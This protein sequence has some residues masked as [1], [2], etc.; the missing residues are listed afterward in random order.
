MADRKFTY[1][2]QGIKQPPGKQIVSSKVDY[3]VRGGNHHA[4][5]KQSFGM[6][7]TAGDAPVGLSGD[8]TNSRFDNFF[9]PT[10]SPDLYSLPYT[11]KD[12]RDLFL[13]FYQRDPYVG[14]AI[15]LLTELPIS[16]VHHT[17]PTTAD[18]EKAHEVLR[19]TKVLSDKINMFELLM[20]IAH[21]YWLYGNVY[22]YVEKNLKGDDIERILILD[23]NVV[24]VEKSYFSSNNSIFL[25]P[26]EQLRHL[27]KSSFI[28]N[29]IR[30]LLNSIPD[31]I[32]R[33]IYDNKKIELNTDPFA[34]TFVHHI[35]RRKSQYDILGEPIL[36]RCLNDLMYRERLRQAQVAIAMRN[37]S[38][39]HLITTTAPL[40]DAQLDNLRDQVDASME[41]PDYVILTTFDVNWN[42]VGAENRLLQ[43]TSEWEE[44]NTRIAAGLGLRKEMIFGDGVFGDTKLGLDVLDKRFSL[45]RNKLQEFVEKKLWAPIC[46]K[47][48]YIERT[49][50]ADLILTP[51][52]AFT[53]L[54]LRDNEAVFNNLFQLYQ[55]GS[56]SVRT[57]LEL[58]N[59]DPD[60]EYEYLQSDLFTLNDARFNDLLA[61]FYQTVGGDLAGD[62]RFKKLIAER[63]L[64]IKNYEDLPTDL[65]ASYKNK[66]VKDTLNRSES[67]SQRVFDKTYIAGQSDKLELNNIQN[68]LI[69]SLAKKVK[70]RYS[71]SKETIPVKK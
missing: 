3:K 28:D 36:R 33:A 25:V 62:P 15:D 38:P 19:Y 35:H 34:G 13:W 43:L 68:M 50:E 9:H 70:N 8:A 58:F 7:F 5:S 42:Q 24:E 4:F 32:Q 2:A 1:S 16:R 44:V 48:G 20:D 51:G 56:L 40:D 67:D 39:K 69:G 52:L 27:I 47:K 46:Y 21:E 12:E 30:K 55:K 31:E 65:T 11:L 45:F 29:D 17:L 10:Y 61:N 71:S 53:R 23:P 14:H 41:T 60:Q 22:I 66:V 57:V 37:L 18:A 6:D 54:T 59:I 64:G 63:G 26:D 49:E